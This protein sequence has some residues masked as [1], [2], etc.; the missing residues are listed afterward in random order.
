M[1]ILDS[2]PPNIKLESTSSSSQNARKLTRHPHIWNFRTIIQAFNL[3]PKQYYE[4]ETHLQGLIYEAKLHTFNWKQ[5]GFKINFL[6]S[7]V[8]EA[9]INKCSW[10][11]SEEVPWWVQE[12]GVK[13]WVQQTAKNMKPTA[14]G[15]KY[16][17]KA[18]RV[19]ECNDRRIGAPPKPKP[20]DPYPL[21]LCKMNFTYRTTKKHPERTIP[22]E[23]LIPRRDDGLL[24]HGKIK[25]AMVGG[26]V[27]GVFDPA[28]EML[29]YKIEEFDGHLVLQVNNASKLRAAL[30]ALHRDLLPWGQELCFEVHDALVSSSPASSKSANLFLCRG[31]LKIKIFPSI[32]AAGCY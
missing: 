15:Q 28:N 13:G 18:T 17:P 26:D 21:S 8:I 6:I 14:S 3:T 19:A 4:A 11:R 20:N 32:R 1:P 29:V 23:S 27:D 25:W 30:L 16:D 5:V 12:H 31:S 22:V 10:L 2:L 7:P 24:D 9:L